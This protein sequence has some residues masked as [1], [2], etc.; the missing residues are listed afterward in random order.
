MKKQTEY[1]L[2]DSIFNIRKESLF[3]FLPVSKKLER[4]TQK[5]AI[6]WSSPEEVAFFLKKELKGVPLNKKHIKRLWKLT[7]PSSWATRFLVCPAYNLILQYYH[8]TPLEPVLDEE[9]NE[10]LKKLRQ[11]KLMEYPK[12]E[13]V[14]LYKITPIQYDL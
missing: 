1:E 4:E 11:Y 3:S 9:E 8:H 7:G 5:D 13:L 10:T 12:T 14:N 2:I 6:Y